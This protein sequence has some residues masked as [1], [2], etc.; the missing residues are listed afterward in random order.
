[1]KIL[2]A[3]D[4]FI[5]PEILLEALARHVPDAETTIVKGNW[6]VTPFADIAEVH[7]AEGDEDALI[8]ALEGCE[9]A[10]VHAPPFTEKVIAAVAPT[11][12]LITV[13]RGGPV[14]INLDAA[15]K[16]GVVVSNAPGRN[17][18]ATA[19]HS[20]AMI[21]AS[22]RQLVDRH[23]ELAAGQWRGDYYAYENVAPEVCG[24]TVGVIGYGA[25]GSRVARTLRAMCADVLA[26]DPY[27]AAADMP[28]ATKLDDL[29]ELLRRS[30]I[31]TLHPRLNDETRGMIGRD[32]LA[33]LPSGAI[34]V[35][36]SRPPVLD[37]DALADALDSGHLYAAAADVLPSEP[38]PPGHRLLR[39][40]RLTLTPH[41]AGAS[42]ESAQLAAELGAADIARWLA[43]E[44]LKY[45]LT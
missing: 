2:V 10:F 17:A 13:G 12:K 41:L 20:V 38:L 39:T 19:E 16:H 23:N 5:L 36:C 29:D 6:P 3:G 28:D 8:R 43:G 31:L 24:S 44:P 9:I 21:L 25:I 45:A 4:R 35:N 40:P 1:M 37:Y 30:T 26:Y 7:E 18:T 11:L 15:A 14:N 32:Q 27:V 33:L 34:V 42:R 22:V